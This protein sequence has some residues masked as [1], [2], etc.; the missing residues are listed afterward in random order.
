MNTVRK[1]SM[2]TKSFQ[3][4]LSI[5]VQ[6]SLYFFPSDK[7]AKTLLLR[8]LIPCPF[9]RGIRPSCLTYF[10]FALAVT[11]FPGRIRVNNVR[12]ARQII[13]SH[14]LPTGMLFGKGFKDSFRSFSPA[15]RH[16]LGK[17][18]VFGLHFIM[19]ILKLFF[20]FFL[21]P[22]CCFIVFFAAGHKNTKYIKRDWKRNANTLAWLSNPS[23]RCWVELNYK[24]L[25]L[26]F[27]C[28]FL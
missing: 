9:F 2:Q 11:P 7:F 14:L 19:W 28:I 21:P 3:L 25:L 13:I 12:L 10:C 5:D 26:L 17:P 23:K 4:N 16:P 24:K 6:L 20:L 22:H 15:H 18:P 1:S 8:A 27:V